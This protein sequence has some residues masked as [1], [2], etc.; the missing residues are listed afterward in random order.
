MYVP[1]EYESIQS[2]IDMS[3]QY[4]TILVAPGIYYENLDFKGRNPTVASYFHYFPEDTQYISQTIID[5]SQGVGSD[6][7]SVVRFVSG[8]TRS[9][10]L[11]GFTIRNGSGS[12]YIWKGEAGKVGGGIYCKGSSPTIINNIVSNNV[13]GAG[14]GIYCAT[15][16]PQILNNVITQNTAGY[17][18]GISGGSP[19]MI[20]ANNFIIENT[21]NDGGGGID[22]ASGIIT[23]NT[24][25]RNS[26]G[27][28]GGGIYV[29]NTICQIQNNIIV[30]SQSGGGIYCGAHPQTVS[31]NNVWNNNGGNFLGCSDWGDTTWGLNRN[32]T[33]CDSFYN[34]SRN[35]IFVAPGTDYHLQDTSSC[36]NAGDNEAPCILSTDFEG[37]P[38]FVNFVDMG[39][40]EYQGSLKGGGAKIASNDTTSEN[41]PGAGAPRTFGL[42]QN[43]PNPFNP[44]TNIQFAVGSEQSLSKISLKIYNL[45]GQLVRILVDEEKTP[46]TYTITWDGKNNSGEEVASGIYFYQVKSEHF[47]DTKRMVLIK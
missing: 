41:K 23:N 7:G 4:I 20:I 43:Y 27:F 29:S 5:G 8:E 22:C 26:A 24:I 9:A 14:G 12:L 44:V 10:T 42:S 37:N 18:G 25:D 32:G 17:G 40:Y 33:P 11:K 35:P 47:T 34:I 13:T 39:A 31:Y 21:A 16:S 45:C 6:T 46:G 3:H 28:L 38:R 1:Q 19:Q 30:N 15:S 2:A 36:I